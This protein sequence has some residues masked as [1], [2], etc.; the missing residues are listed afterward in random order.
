LQYAEHCYINRVFII[1]ILLHGIYFPT[2]TNI[3]KLLYKQDDTNPTDSSNTTPHRHTSRESRN[4]TKNQRRADEPPFSDA[5][6]DERNEEPS[7]VASDIVERTKDQL[8]RMGVDMDGV[9]QAEKTTR[10]IINYH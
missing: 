7:L 10:F 8:R 3:N 5:S 1:L 2:Q 4:V 9:E 6:S